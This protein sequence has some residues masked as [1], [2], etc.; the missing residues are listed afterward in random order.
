MGIEM[1]AKRLNGRFIFNLPPCKCHLNALTVEETN[2]IIRLHKLKVLRKVFG[3]LSKLEELD[4]YIEGY[5]AGIRP[6]E[7]G[8]G[9]RFSFNIYFDFG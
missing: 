4:K 1:A 9:L 2:E 3:E 7:K 5:P 6:A 8:E